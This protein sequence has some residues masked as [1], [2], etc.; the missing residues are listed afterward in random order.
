MRTVLFIC[1]GNTC[2]SP[3]A[4]AIARHHLDQGLLGEPADIF[5]ASAGVQAIDGAR[6][7]SETLTTLQ[8]MG[9]PYSGRSKRLTDQMIR[10]ADLVFCMTGQQQA[11]ARELVADSQAD[12]DKIVLLEP[13]SDINDPIGLG[14]EAYNSLGQRLAKIVPKRLKEILSNA[15]NHRS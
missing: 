12:M 13:E 8:Q 7:T 3:M 6:T 2:R 11:M 4:E 15:L 1:T 14:Q 10:R 9:I 5:V